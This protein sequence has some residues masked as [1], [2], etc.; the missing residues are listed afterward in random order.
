[1]NKSKEYDSLEIFLFSSLFS[2]FFNI[3]CMWPAIIYCLLE[4]HV[5]K[6]NPDG[7]EEEEEE[8]E[9]RVSEKWGMGGN[10]YEA[11]YANSLSHCHSMP[12]FVP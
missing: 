12:S 7:W 9:Q 5:N 11:V 2:H 4:G 8:D 10:E 6:S 3:I 1:M